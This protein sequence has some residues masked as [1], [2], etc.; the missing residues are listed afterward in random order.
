M[1]NWDADLYLRFADERTQPAVDLLGRVH[2]DAPRRVI[3]LGCGPGNSTALLRQRWPG[4]EI[5]GLD[6]S[7]EMIAAAQQSHPE[8]KWLI[9]DVRSWTD[10][11]PFDV[12]FSNA[13]FQWVPDHAAL[14]PRLLRMVNPGGVLAVQV[15][16]HVQSPVHQL[17]LEISQ[18]PEWNGRM[19]AARAAIT[20]ESPAFYYDVLQPLAARIDLWET[21]YQHVLDGPAAILAWIRGTGLRPF[22][23]ALATDAERHRFEEL[24]LAGVEQAYARRVDGRVL[25][26]FRRLFFVAY[27]RA[28]G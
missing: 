14:V 9:A 3:D 10:P 21:E 2:V 27:R 20:V 11:V 25:F 24:L 15:P 26:P 5:I 18:R 12:I 17:M 22:L 28:E 7:P 4:A 8:G 23:E 19:D 1:P 13:A 6:H 16:R